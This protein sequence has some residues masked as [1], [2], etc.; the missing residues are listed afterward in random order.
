MGVIGPLREGEP[1]ELTCTSAGGRPPPSVGWWSGGAKIQGR[2]EVGVSGGGVVEV[3]SKIRVFGGRDL[4]SAAL[5]C[6]AKLHPRGDVVLQPRVT[7][8]TLNV[9]RKSC[10]AFDTRS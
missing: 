7:S 10:D 8:V 2:E 6:E 3:T 5:K 1:T 4:A 9:T